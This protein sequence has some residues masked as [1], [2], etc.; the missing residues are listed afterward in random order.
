MRA[1]HPRPVPCLVRSRLRHLV[2]ALAVSLTALVLTTLNVA[3]PRPPTSAP[4]PMAMA[5]AA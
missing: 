4:L 1:I 2:R 5:Q 3:A